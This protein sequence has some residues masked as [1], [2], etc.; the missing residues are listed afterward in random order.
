MRRFNIAGP[1]NPRNHYMIPAERRVEMVRRLV[2]DQAYFVVHAPRQSGKTTSFQALARRLTAEGRYT[3]ALLTLEVGARMV[4]DIGASELAILDD[5]GAACRAQLPAELL[6]PPWPDAPPGRRLGAAL[7]AWSRASGRPLVLL[8]DEVDALQDDTLISVLRQLRA[9]FQ[10][11]PEHFPW[12]MALIGLRD[13]RDYLLQAGSRLGTASPFNVKEEAIGLRNFTAEEVA[14]LYGQHTTE[15][16]QVF[17]PEAVARAFELTQGQPWLTNAL[18]REITYKMEVPLETAI[19]L[20]H[21]ETARERLVQARATHLDSLLARLRE[22]RV[23]PIVAA[24]V[25]G[26][27]PHSLDYASDDFRYVRDLGL[28]RLGPAGAEAANPIYREVLARELAYNTQA[29]LPAPW[30]RWQTPDGRLDMPALLD[31]FLGWWRENCEILYETEQAPYREAAAH[32][33]LMGFLQR[34]V[35]GGGRVTREYAAARGRVDLLV[36]YA[37]ERFA[38][39]LKRVPPEHRS[40]RQVEAEGIRQLAGYLERLGLEEGWLVI[41]DQRKHRPWKPRLWRKERQVE[42]RRLHLIGA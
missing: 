8:L 2:D 21:I 14:E 22:P 5:W 7:E 39:E 40:A 28:I 11:R 16:G 20:D 29:A 23:A 25:L 30:W 9:G 4:T 32:L 15:T 17:Q 31:A 19:A 37:G 3:A 34:V 1:C 41:F 26:D 36:E 13:V 18:A 35:N 10:R 38:I 12:S 42:G 24:A 33:A 27:V 6:P